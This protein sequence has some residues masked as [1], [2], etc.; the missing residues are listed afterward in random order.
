M[1]GLVDEVAV[2]ME[3]IRSNKFPTPG[4]SAIV[5]VKPSPL[6]GTTILVLVA[7]IIA[8]DAQA[9]VQHIVAA[10]RRNLSLAK[11]TASCA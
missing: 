9:A 3:Y 2:A 8:R 5:L 4:P 7:E 1:Q 10:A 11:S 6:Q